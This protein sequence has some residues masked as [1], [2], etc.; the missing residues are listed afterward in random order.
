MKVSF[1]VPFSTQMAQKTGELE[2]LCLMVEEFGGLDT[3][4]MLQCHSNEA[5]SKSAFNIIEKFFSEDVSVVPT[6]PSVI[7]WSI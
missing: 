3:V 4:E 5:V 2:K 7:V 6:F 1:F